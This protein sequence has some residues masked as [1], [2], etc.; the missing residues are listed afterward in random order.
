MQF[1]GEDVQEDSDSDSEGT[2]DEEYIADSTNE[3]DINDFDSKC[4]L[5]EVISSHI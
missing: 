5:K 3:S 1:I 2:E 4:L